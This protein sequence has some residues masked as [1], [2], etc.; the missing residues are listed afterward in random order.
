MSIPHQQME[1]DTNIGSLVPVWTVDS[2]IFGH[3][4]VERERLWSVDSFGHSALGS[5]HNSAN[6]CLSSPTVFGT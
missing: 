2:R 3:L 6:D 1:P 4:E 5:P